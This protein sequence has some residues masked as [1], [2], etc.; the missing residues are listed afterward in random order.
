MMD[1]EDN[2]FY[3]KPIYVYSR[4]QALEDGVLV[5]VTQMAKE[6]G[7][8]IPVAVTRAVWDSYIVWS[9]EDSYKQTFQDHEG[10]L[11]DILWMLHL[12]SKRNSEE[13]FLNYRLFV[14]P[15]DGRSK[16]P[17]QIELKAVIGGGDNGQAVITVMLPDED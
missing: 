17:R 7:F 15:R 10:R 3:G 5:D 11:W 8:K 16:K 4:A 12:A 14:I 2:S 6:A 1:N 13:A 9:N